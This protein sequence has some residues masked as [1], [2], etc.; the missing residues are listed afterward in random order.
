[1][2]MFKRIVNMFSHQ[3]NVGENNNEKLSE[4]L[5]CEGENGDVKTSSI[6]LDFNELK[7]PSEKY[8]LCAWSHLCKK[9]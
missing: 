1:M 9:H 3:K 7:I 2:K 5:E 8:S 4:K 6:S